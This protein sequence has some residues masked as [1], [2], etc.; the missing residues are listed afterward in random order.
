MKQTSHF[1]PKLAQFA[2]L[3]FAGLL[4]FSPP[5]TARSTPTAPPSTSAIEMAADPFT[6]PSV[7]LSLYL[8]VGCTTQTSQ[9]EQVVTVQI[10]PEDASWRLLIRTPR[11]N[12][13]KV[14][15]KQV[16]DHSVEQLL[17]STAIRDSQNNTISTKAKV[18]ENNTTLIIAGKPAGR[19]Y[20]SLPQA[21]NQPNVIK[22][23]TAFQV[24]SGKFVTFELTT[25]ESQLEKVRPVY[26]TIVSGASF[27]DPG[28]LAT[29]RAA[30]VQAGILMF[31]QFSSGQMAT[32]IQTNADR[33]ERLYEPATSDDDAMER[34]KG[35]RRIRF[36]KGFRG[37]LDPSK[38]RSKWAGL[39]H[40]EGYIA[41]IDARLLIDDPQSNAVQVYD[42]IGIFFM[43]PDRKD[44]AW[45]VKMT[46][47]D[48]NT[49][50]PWTEIGARQTN[51]VGKITI[52]VTTQGPGIS[53]SH[54]QP[55]I[56]GQGYISRLET[57]ILPQILIAHGIEADFGFYTYQPAGAGGAVHLRRDLLE[58]VPSRPGLYKITTHQ[59]EN[60]EP[61]ISFFRADGSLIQ[62][63][64][65]DG[66]TWEPITF[67]RLL[68]IWKA[69][70]LPT[71]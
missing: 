33:F 10:I 11:S 20:V 8:P 65:P 30:A 13:P 36:S 57:Y 31:D 6:L 29:S 44:E 64:L 51:D 55:L 32:L 50:R 12:D 69:K 14:T 63:T 25:F 49:N 2:S 43:T 58:Q 67:E 17:A 70:G 18:I 22:G 4:L 3:S 16:I 66:R 60:A 48:G 24:G 56:Q 53:P 39:D 26:E 9:I 41:Q 54:T 5:A 28:D 40:Q 34:E 38:S 52:N 42:S 35:Y 46:L 23:F 45:L 68:K 15:I 59:T 71:Q 19:A 37:E 27:T 7:G 47:R 21:N 61:Q 1:T 62:T